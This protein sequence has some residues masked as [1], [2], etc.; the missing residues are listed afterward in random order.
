[1]EQRLSLITLAVADMARARRFYEEGLGWRPLQVLDEVAFYQLPGLGLALFQRQAIEADAHRRID[2][3]FSGMSVAINE[4]SEAAV[5]AVFAEVVAA[6]G[7]IL[8]SPGRTDWGGYSGYFADV[9]GHT[10]EVAHNPAC[11]IHSDGGTSFALA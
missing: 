7:S 5:D 9:D 11:T 3:V 2:G 10:W 8:K 1:M 6:G 4:R